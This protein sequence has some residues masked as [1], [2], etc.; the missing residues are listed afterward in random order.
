[1][2]EDWIDTLCDVWAITVNEFTVVRSYKLIQ[3]TDFPDSIDPSELENTPIALTRP[4]SV[5]PLYS[6]GR[7]QLTWYGVTEFHVAPDID[8]GR[9]SALL[10][11]YERI[12]QAAALKVQLSGATAEISHF[13]ISDRPDG[14]EGPIGLTFGNEAEHWGFVVRWEVQESLAG[15]ALPVSG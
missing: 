12:L 10:P 14:I 2:I 1:M 13:I 9:I 7:K 8:R 4:G 3:D 5:R 6:K 15:N 11:W